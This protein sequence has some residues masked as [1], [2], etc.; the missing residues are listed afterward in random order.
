MQQPKPTY[1][2]Q[3]SVAPISEFAE[4]LKTPWE[5]GIMTHNGP[6]LRRLEQTIKDDLNLSNI[7]IVINGTLA[8][9]IP[10]RAMGLRGEIIT[11]PFSWIATSSAIIW[12]HCTPV[13][14]DIDPETFNIDPNKIE[15]AVTEKT[16]AILPV[17]VSV[18]RATA[19]R[20][21][22]SGKSTA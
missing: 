11:T 8:M 14:V 9:E 13:F 2:V 7:S 5:S 6:L 20:L 16:V 1:V 4:L 3:P 12:Q 21:T 19:R 22:R 15:D 18:P 10:I 17:H